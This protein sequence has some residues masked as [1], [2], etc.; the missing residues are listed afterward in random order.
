MSKYFLRKNLISGYKIG[1]ICIFAM[2]YYLIIYF[3][4]NNQKTKYINIDNIEGEIISSAL[5]TFADCATRFQNS[6][7]LAKEKPYTH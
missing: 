2:L 3:L 4:Y 1:S 7:H 5:N 6:F